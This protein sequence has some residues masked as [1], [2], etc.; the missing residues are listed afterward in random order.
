MLTGATRLNVIVGDPIAQVKSPGG[1]T[2][3]FAERGHDGIVVPVRIASDDLADFLVVADR[4]TNLDGIIVTVPHKFACRAHC[5]TVTERAA[6]LRAV[7][8]M[9]RRPEGGWHGEMVDG[10]G[11]VGALRAEGFDPA[12]ARALLV[13][14]GGA[15]SAIALALVE[16]GVRELAIADADAARR[17]DL[18]ARLARRG[19]A[20]VVAGAPDPAGY[21]LVANATP[22]G[23]RPGDP[24][25][26]DV[27]RLAPETFVGCVITAPAVSPL[28]AAA[29]ER[30][31]RTTTGTQMYA[32]LQAAMVAFLM[33]GARVG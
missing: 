14:A 29:R 19:G 4:V 33:D 6:F 11:F 18:V 22:A 7:N 26:V 12:G 21:D 27:G 10:L 20:R 25:P 5:A 16:A 15:G 2:A 30:G 13:G 3:A 24:L 8:I 9:R 23:M 17:D 31:C 32:A 28:V 1:M